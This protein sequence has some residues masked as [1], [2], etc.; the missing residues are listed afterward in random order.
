MDQLLHGS[1]IAA[2]PLTSTTD[3][4]TGRL[5][6]ASTDVRRLFAQ[7]TELECSEFSRRLNLSAVNTEN[8]EMSA[9]E[10]ASKTVDRQRLILTTIDER[11]SCKPSTAPDYGSD[12]QPTTVR[13]PAMSIC[14]AFR[15]PRHSE[16]PGRRRINC[17]LLERLDDLKS[18]TACRQ[19]RSMSGAIT[20]PRNS[21]CISDLTSMFYRTCSLV[22]ADSHHLS[23]SPTRRPLSGSC[24]VFFCTKTCCHFGF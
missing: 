17:S 1:Y 22:V 16:L 6:W 12:K 13:P 24:I 8:I 5:I 9:N 15:H 20:F 3:H 11:A 7:N 23:L 2:T 19:N 21:P 14:T 10:N 18:L 4:L